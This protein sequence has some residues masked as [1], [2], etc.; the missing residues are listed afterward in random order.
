MEPVLSSA[1]QESVLG[2]LLFILFTVHL[3]DNLGNKIFPMLMT[4]LYLC[5]LLIVMI[6]LVWLDL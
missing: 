5:T 2:P 1:P 4:L 6:T 3:V